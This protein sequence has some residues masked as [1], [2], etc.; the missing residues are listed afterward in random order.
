MKC[1][2]GNSCTNLSDREAA[3]TLFHNTPVRNIVW[4]FHIAIENQTELASS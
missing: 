2:C 4:I 1:P 3:C